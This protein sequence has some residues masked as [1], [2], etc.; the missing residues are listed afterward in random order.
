MRIIYLSSA[1]SAY[2]HMYAFEAHTRG[3]GEAGVTE[4]EQHQ[5]FVPT[6][7]AERRTLRKRGVALL[8]RLAAPSGGRG[9]EDSC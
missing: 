1:Y 2:V 4:R 8:K 7:P 9:E 5:E 6:M 3:A